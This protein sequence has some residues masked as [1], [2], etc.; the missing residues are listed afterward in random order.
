MSTGRG[1]AANKRQR[2]V[3]PVQDD[4]AVV[5]SNDAVRSN[6]SGI[7]AVVDAIIAER[8]ALQKDVSKLREENDELTSRVSSLEFHEEENTRLK[9]E[10]DLSRISLDNHRSSEEKLSEENKR[11]AA[12]GKQLDALVKSASQH[13]NT[14]DQE[15]EF[16]RRKIQE[17]D[18][19]IANLKNNLSHTKQELTKTMDNAQ[20]LRNDFL[21][22]VKNKDEEIAKNTDR[23]QKL[24]TEV[25]KHKEECERLKDTINHLNLHINGLEAKIQDNSQDL[26]TRNEELEHDLEALGAEL[27][28]AKD[29]LKE[30]EDIY[31]DSVQLEPVGISVLLNNGSMVPIPQVYKLWLEAGLLFSGTPTHSIRCSRTSTMA[32]VVHDPAICNFISRVARSTAL[33][34]KLPSYFRFSVRPS[35]FTGQL[36]WEE[37][38]L[39]DQLTLMAKL[40]HMLKQPRYSSRFQVTL[41]DNHVVTAKYDF[42]MATNE[43]ELKFTLSVI[44]DN[45]SINA[46]R[47]D[48]VDTPYAVGGSFA[49]T[50]ILPGNVK[51][52]TE[53]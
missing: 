30:V 13:T 35:D 16:G 1:S 12:Y 23:I 49:K 52:V 19:H 40:I 42:T 53:L 38:K 5:I 46:H 24:D 14:L 29:K 51:I 11:L 6:V 47:I 25:A 41:S 26:R 8:D 21:T 22:L 3:P 44:S 15:L 33:D 50:K 32:S 18:G 4:R 31:Y 37:Y 36:V 34:T 28:Q 20:V 10:L 43:V 27:R 7:A 45:G 48:F 17:L 9:N 39:Y 2:A